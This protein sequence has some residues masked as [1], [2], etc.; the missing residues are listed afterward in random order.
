[1]S[2]YYNGI[3]KEEDRQVKF[4]DKVYNWWEGLTEQRQFDIMLGF[5]PSA[6]N[7]DT[8]IDK[9]FGDMPNICQTEIYLDNNSYEL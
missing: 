5:Y 2:N 7:K 6:V 1:M 3:N 4:M 9:M 8:N